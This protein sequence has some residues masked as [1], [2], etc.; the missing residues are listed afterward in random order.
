MDTPD[1][2][3]RVVGIGFIG[4]PS[5]NSDTAFVCK[6]CF[7]K[8]NIKDKVLRDEDGFHKKIPLPNF[9]MLGIK[10]GESI[11]GKPCVHQSMVVASNKQC[12]GCYDIGN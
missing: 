12:L 1:S 2:C 7:N 5:C 11:K 10:C 3:T 6:N 4:N 9:N 8:L